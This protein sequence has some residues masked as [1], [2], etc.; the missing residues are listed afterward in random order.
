MNELFKKI[1]IGEAELKELD[2]Y[3]NM[4]Y[5]VKN[6]NDVAKYFLKAARKK[7]KDEKIKKRN[8]NKVIDIYNDL[9]N[10]NKTIK[11]YIKSKESDP[12]LLKDAEHIIKLFLDDYSNSGENCSIWVKTI[13]MRGFVELMI[14][15]IIVTLIGVYFLGNIYLAI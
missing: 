13:N 4:N 1:I 7:Y 3:S 12:I 5:K 2:S 11:K 14:L 15:F 8:I 6:L 10:N 9:I